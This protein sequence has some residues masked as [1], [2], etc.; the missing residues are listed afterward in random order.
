MLKFATY[1]IKVEF[2][3]VFIDSNTQPCFGSIQFIV[4]CYFSCVNL[5]YCL[6]E[7][8]RKDL[9]NSHIPYESPFFPLHEMIFFANTNNHQGVAN[10]PI[11]DWDNLNVV[12]GALKHAS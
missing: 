8:N 2:K 10:F 6:F 12:N 3:L 1:T 4:L 11:K 9:A 5:S 7:V